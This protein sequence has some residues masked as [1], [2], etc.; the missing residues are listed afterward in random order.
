MRTNKSLEE[1]ITLVE[2]YKS[3]K[4]CITKNGK[5]MLIFIKKYDKMS[6]ENCYENIVFLKENKLSNNPILI[7]EMKD[8]LIK[9][10]DHFLRQCPKKFLPNFRMNK[11]I[12]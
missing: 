4:S 5:H 2:E 9:L 1:C 7:D 8:E 3:L 10:C 11:K 12:H 6:A